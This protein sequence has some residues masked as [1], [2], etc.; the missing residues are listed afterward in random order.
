MLDLQYRIANKNYRFANEAKS[1]VEGVKDRLVLDEKYKQ[2]LLN[3]EQKDLTCGNISRLFAW[4]TKKGTFERKPPIIDTRA[5]CKLAAGEF[6]N[7]EA[8]ETT[9]GSILFNKLFVEGICDHVIPNGYMNDVM[10]DKKVGALSNMIADGYRSGKVTYEQLIKYLKNIEFYGLN[11]STI[12]SPSFTEK[13]IKPDPEVMKEKEKLLSKLPD[14][15]TLAQV[16]DIENKLVAL[17]S[18]NTEGDPGRTLY[19]SGSRGSFDNDYKVLSTMVGAVVNPVTG[20]PMLVEGNYITGID[21]KDI[22]ALGVAAVA[23]CYPKA[24]G[25]QVGGYLT[26]QFYAVYQSITV[27]EDGTDCGTKMGLK[28]VLTKDN[29]KP[30]LYQNIQLKD[31]KHVT[32]TEENKTDFFN[33]EVI[34][35]SPMFC[36]NDKICSVCAGRTPYDFEME[37]IGLNAGSISNAILNKKMK[38]FHETKVKFDSVDIDS[39]IL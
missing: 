19:D 26:K 23:G 10:T 34:I 4:T 3:M 5:I 31:G 21:K 33:K 29:Y 16:V 9:A 7:K 15:P 11:L 39:L 37:N 18:K 1:T 6:T 27:D 38:L 20:E 13:V 28:K 8:V 32:L 30:Y 24:V 35:R 17:A 12:F 25:T 2:M 22:T 14:N 36:T